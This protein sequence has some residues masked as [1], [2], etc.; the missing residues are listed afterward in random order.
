MT[1]GKIKLVL[2]ST[3]AL[4]SWSVAWSGASQPFSDLLFLDWDGFR[5]ALRGRAK[6]TS[7]LLVT[8]ITSIGASGNAD[9]MIPGTIP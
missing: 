3:A 7:Q 8:C 1:N 6:I 4:A 5:S 2:F 9:L